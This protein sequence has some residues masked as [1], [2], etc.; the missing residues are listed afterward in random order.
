MWQLLRNSPQPVAPARVL[1]L[2]PLTER[3]LSLLRFKMAPRHEG[4][5]LDFGDEISLVDDGAPARHDEN[6]GDESDLVSGNVQSRL[7]DIRRR[8]ALPG[9]IE[10]RFRHQSD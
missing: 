5:V 1:R 9:R 8:S 3:T 2:K 4:Q 7:V 6:R 10:F